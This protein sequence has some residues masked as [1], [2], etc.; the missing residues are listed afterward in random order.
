MVEELPP[1]IEIGP[2]ELEPGTPFYYEA[3]GIRYKFKAGNWRISDIVFRKKSDAEDWM[4][5]NI[6]KFEGM[7]GELIPVKRCA[8]LELS[9]NIK[10]WTEELG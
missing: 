3:W 5:K 7:E 2:I 1:E 9:G 6:L 4:K 8:L 10:T